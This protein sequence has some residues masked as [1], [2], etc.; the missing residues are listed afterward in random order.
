MTNEGPRKF[1]PKKKMM[2]ISAFFQNKIIVMD[3]TFSK[4]KLI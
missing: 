3:E 2:G 1:N 4:S